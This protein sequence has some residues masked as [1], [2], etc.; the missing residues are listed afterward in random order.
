MIWY[1]DV[2]H[3]KI[4]KDPA[5]QEKHSAMRRE[6][7]ER[8]QAIAGVPCEVIHYTDVTAKLAC[9]K[10]V[11]AIA[12][13]GCRSDWAEYDFARFEPLFNMVR[14]GTWPTIGFC[15]GGQLIYMAFGG[16][17]GPLGE[18]PAGEGDGWA[19]YHPGMIKERG[20]MPVHVRQGDPIWAG[21]G[22]A[23]VFWE[24]HYWEMKEPL[25]PVFALLASTDTCRVQLIK[26][27]QHCIYGTQF[28]PEGYS[29]DYRDGA[30]FLAN[31]FDIA[32]VR[33]PA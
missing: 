12:M 20:F 4:A 14:A 15:G 33:R 30:R 8:L 3:E 29:D 32:G 6:R 17:C 31:F 1:I 7:G 18:L 19:E 13:S 9:E 23:P 28:H 25:P 21:L 26:H 10:G 24:A 2:E 11:Q 22:D 16:T 5:Q 27:R